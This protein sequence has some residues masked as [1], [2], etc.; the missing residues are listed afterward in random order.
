[1]I[2][3]ERCPF[4]G[5]D[6]AEPFN[7]DNNQNSSP[8]WG[9]FCA[10]CDNA[11]STCESE[12]K[13]A[14]LWNDLSEIMQACTEVKHFGEPL[15]GGCMWDLKDIKVRVKGC[16]PIFDNLVARCERLRKRVVEQEASKNV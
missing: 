6:E 13:A 11:I 8:V 5:A 9:V 3:L 1:M 15:H 12:E 10:R 2:N 16:M 4:C 7:E 14:E